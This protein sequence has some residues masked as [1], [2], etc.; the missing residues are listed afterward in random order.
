M[1]VR[2]RGNYDEFYLERKVFGLFWRREKTTFFTTYTAAERALRI[3]KQAHP[4][5][6]I[7]P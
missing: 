2:I 3:L 5:V 6:E 1:K 4:T 7:E